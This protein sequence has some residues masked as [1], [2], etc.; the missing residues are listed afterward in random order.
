MVGIDLNEHKCAQINVGQSYIGDVPGAT[1]AEQVQAGRLRATS[2]F[3]ALSSADVA[4]IWVPTPLAKS[5]DP[6]ISYI[7]AAA[8]GFARQPMK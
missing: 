8:D 4:M 2:D 7:V 6:D 5:K 1:V 3:E